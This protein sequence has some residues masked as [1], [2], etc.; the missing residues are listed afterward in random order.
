MN[1]KEKAEVEALSDKDF[2]AEWTRAAKEL[3]DVKER[4]LF[5]SKEKQRRDAL[6]RFNQFSD[7]EKAAFAQFAVAEGIPSKEEVN[8]G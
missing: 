6:E 1:K 3:E 7:E 4:C 5:F 2:E 8:N